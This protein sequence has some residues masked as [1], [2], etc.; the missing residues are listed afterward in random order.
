MRLARLTR[1]LSLLLAATA[2]LPAALLAR[3]P[4]CGGGEAGLVVQRSCCCGPVT[5]DC[6]T[7]MSKACACSSQ[8]A[9]AGPERR[10]AAS[11]ELS[12]LVA[13]PAATR[14]STSA[15]PA[16]AARPLA[17]TGHRA[18]GCELLRLHCVNLI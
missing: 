13:L 4:S 15:A 6:G 16:R 18:A 9:P 12:S 8:P 10:V 11:P 7:S 3:A 14:P 1:A 5:P 2:V 17:P